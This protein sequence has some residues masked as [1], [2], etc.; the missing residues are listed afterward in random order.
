MKKQLLFSAFLSLTIF[1]AQSQLYIDGKNINEDSSVKYI[2]IVHTTYPSYFTIEWIDVGKYR[3]SVKMTNTEGKR[4]GFKSGIELLRHME[5]S[6]WEM[7]RKD[8]LFQARRD[9]AF[10]GSTLAFLLFERRQR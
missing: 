2:E 8:M 4:M 3:N 5:D 7:V 10:G 9:A 6:G 1:T